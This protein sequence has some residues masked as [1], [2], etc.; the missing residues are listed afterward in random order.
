MSESQQP[1]VSV[2]TPV[3][4]NG[5]YMRECIESVLAQ[6]Y[7]NWEYTI[8]N[9]CSTDETLSV[10][11]EH[12]RKDS[13]IRVVSNDTLLDVISNHNRAFTLI[14]A[15]SKYCKVVSGDDW[16]FPECLARLVAVA[17][18]HPSVGVVGSYQLSGWGSDWRA[19]RIRWTELPYPSEVIPGREVCRLQL[20][21]GPYVFG[22]PTSTLYRA[23]F[24]RADDHFYPN[25][26]AEADTSAI[27][28]ALQCS[29]F[30][31][32][33]QVLSYDRVHQQTQSAV[34]RNLNAY[35]SSR[36][37]DLIVYGPS[38]LSE[39]ELKRRTEEILDRYYHYLA[40]NAVHF[41]D[42]KFWA[43]HKR[44]LQEC[45]HPFSRT[46]FAKALLAKVIDLALNP[47]Q[48]AEKAYRN[49]RTLTV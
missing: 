22:T 18:A 7:S 14:S 12:A 9:N 36:L 5:P 11:Q 39:S 42:E 13:R 23:D 30:G 1:L 19:W 4:N 37:S 10:A 24:V 15:H 48:T 26:T 40:V 8:V 29:D 6:T 32:V 35:E 41:R 20:L 16:L 46:R 43:Y 34:S 49:S 47:K 3:Y 21:G 28:K 25:L 38:F 17:E 33:H 45:G 44:R 31:F 27:Y 2:V